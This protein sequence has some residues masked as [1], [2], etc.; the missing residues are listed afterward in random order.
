MTGTKKPPSGNTLR[1]VLA[2]LVASGLFAAIFLLAGILTGWGA[3]EV[4]G[5]RVILTLAILVPALFIIPWGRG[6]VRELLAR[7]RAHPARLPLGILGSGLVGVQLWLFMWAPI[8]GMAISVSLGY[9]LLPLVMVLVGRVIFGERLSSAQWIAVAFA[10]VGVLFEALFAGGLAWPTLMVALGYPLYFVMRRMAGF[11]SLAAFALEL[12]I[13]LPAAVYFVLAGPHGITGPPL[14]NTGFLATAAIGVLGALA[15]FLFL[16]A[17]KVLPLSLFGLLGY[18][19]PV[20][21]L[22]VALIL[23]E[24]VLATDALTYIPLFLA[25]LVLAADGYRSTRRQPRLRGSHRNP[26]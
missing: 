20:L 8:N 24:K 1:G 12:L 15:M 17:S 14:I 6:M 10:G 3:E 26:E 13:L 9:F 16:G 25:L 4:F 5:W 21:L 22:A 7:L 11:E 19:E 2:S 18:V 23:G